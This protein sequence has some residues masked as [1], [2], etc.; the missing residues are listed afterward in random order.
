[1]RARIFERFARGEHA[2]PGMGLGL[3]LA[4]T[5]AGGLGAR[6]ELVDSERGARFRLTFN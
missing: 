4:R 3:P 1:L 2:K 5:L 6:L